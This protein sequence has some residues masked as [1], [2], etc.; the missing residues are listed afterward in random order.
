MRRATALVLL[1]L[2]WAAAW[3]AD[4]SEPGDPPLLFQ[5]HGSAGGPFGAGA[6]SLAYDG[7]RLSAGVAV[8]VTDSDPGLTRLHEA[9]FARLRFVR[10]GPLSLTL[11]TSLARADRDE[12]ATFRR[13]SHVDESIEWRW[14]PAYRVDGALG[15]RLA[16]G[17]Y[18]LGVEG[19]LGYV[20]NRPTC[21]YASELSFV[22]GSCADPAIPSE[23][24][25]TKPNGRVSPHVGASLGVR[26][27]RVTRPTASGDRDDDVRA[28]HAWIAP[29]ALTRPAGSFTFTTY[30]LMLV[31]ATYAFTDR[32]QASVGAGFIWPD[33]GPTLLEANLRG[34]VVRWRQLRG[35]IA[36]GV[37]SV[38]G[39][40]SATHLIGAG[41]VASVCLDDRC[42]SVLSLA[43]LAGVV[44]GDYEGNDRHGRGAIVAPSAVVAVLRHLKLVG[45]VNALVASGH[46]PDAAW[47]LALRM[48][49]RTFAAELGTMRGEVLV[50]TL[51]VGL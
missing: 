11:G 44:R 28:P 32:V 2:A 26:L 23:L 21:S 8:G 40:Y 7:P 9:L 12:S 15:A 34:Q 36:A 50:G 48:P 18:E 16:F 17:A 37:F 35:T 42:A 6:V 49:Y 45:E 38:L 25:A 1:L 43:G 31:E 4:A 14:R 5:L 29:T 3:P 22:E 19:G 10:F 20:W 30:Q 13:P 46:H 41:P 51:A 27:D 39:T 33:N 47:T 24:R